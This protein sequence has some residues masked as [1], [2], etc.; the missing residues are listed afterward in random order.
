MSNT[1]HPSAYAGADVTL[2]EPIRWRSWPLV[3][4]PVRTAAVLLT[5]LAI[6]I[7]VR[8]T[9]GSWALG[10]LAA[11][12]LSIALWRF[13]VPI[14]FGL[15]E[16]GVDQ[17]ISGR[18]LRISWR[19]IRRYRVCSSGVLLMPHSDRII[20]APFHGLYLPWEGHAD[21]V[22]AYMQH[23]LEPSQD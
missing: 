11:A 3:Q 2:L 1:Q 16:A 13:F 4:T 20:M 7:L 19:A 23:Y 8:V 22:L 18:Q 14:T 15:S 9:A 5:I 21:E 17:W 6:G 12:S 10:L